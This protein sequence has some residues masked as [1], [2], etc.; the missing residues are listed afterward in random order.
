MR[1]TDACKNPAGIV[2]GGALFSLADTAGA[3]AAVCCGTQVVTVESAIKYLRPA[4]GYPI[5]HGKSQGS[6]ARQADQLL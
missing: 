6:E 2:H 3:N 5:S 1:V 4:R